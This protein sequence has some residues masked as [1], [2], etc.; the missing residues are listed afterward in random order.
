M[1]L[2]DAKSIHAASAAMA[3]SIEA[4][5][6]TVADLADTWT[7]APDELVNLALTP[8]ART[9]ATAARDLAELVLAGVMDAA[10]DGDTVASVVPILALVPLPDPTST[11]AHLA[12]FR[13]AGALLAAH[14][15][16]IAA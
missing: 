16:L 12:W 10:E 9:A 15:R 3:D 1:S 4:H 11:H 6:H 7:A 2:A 8:A 14:S 13:T 5:R